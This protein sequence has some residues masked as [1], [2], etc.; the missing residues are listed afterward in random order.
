[1]PKEL[2]V[3]P[4]ATR[5]ASKIRFADIPINAY[6]RPFAEERARLGDATLKWVFR[7]MLVVREFE[8]MLSE[9]KAKGAYSGIPFAYRGPAHLSKE[10]Y[11]LI[12]P[13]R[14]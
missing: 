14:S 13:W 11:V 9:F 2:L 3:D 8:T 10:P 7:A 4:S 12:R 5:A 1:M 6:R